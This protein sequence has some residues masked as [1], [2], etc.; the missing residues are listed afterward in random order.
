M[1]NFIVENDIPVFCVTASSFPDGVMA[2]HQKLHSLVTFRPD[3]KYFGLSRPEGGSI[4]YMAA[5]EEEQAGEGE[6]L[7][8]ETLVI[9]K[10]I[11]TSA[12][13]HDYMNDIPA[14][15]KTFQQMIADPRIDPQGYCVEWYL[16]QKD[17]RC[18]VRLDSEIA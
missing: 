15:G 10:G 14:I 4:K 11:Y 2:A 9:R 17:V 6:K 5:T 7:G 12:V 18:M 16:S 3:R 8:C 1:E 13:I